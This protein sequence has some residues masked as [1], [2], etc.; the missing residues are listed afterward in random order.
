MLRQDVCRSELIPGL[1]ADV[2]NVTCGYKLDL[3][4]AALDQILVAKHIGFRLEWVIDLR[5]LASGQLLPT[6]PA[7]PLV[8]PT[9][10]S[11]PTIKPAER[12][13]DLDS[14]PD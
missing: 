6:T 1:P 11:L 10:A 7:L 2:V 8:P 5:E 12:Q 9:P 14:D 4:E 3:A 13:A